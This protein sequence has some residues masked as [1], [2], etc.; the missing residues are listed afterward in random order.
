M[1]HNNLGGFGPDGGEPILRYGGVAS[2]D[3]VPI[4]LIIEVV[5]DPVGG[6][7]A[8]DTSVNGLGGA[9]PGTSSVDGDVTVTA[10]QLADGTWSVSVELSAEGCCGAPERDATAAQEAADK[11]NAM[12]PAQMDELFGLDVISTEPAVIVGTTRIVGGDVVAFSFIVDADSYDPDTSPASYAAALAEEMGPQ[13]SEG[14]GGFGQ[15]N[16]VFGSST[17]LRYTFVFGGTKGT[18]ADVIALTLFNWNLYDIGISGITDAAHAEHP[19]LMG[20]VMID[21]SDQGFTYTLPADAKLGTNIVV[22]ESGSETWFMSNNNAA[23]AASNG[24]STSSSTSNSPPTDPENLTN[25]QKANEVTLA[26]KQPTSSFELVFAFG[27]PKYGPTGISLAPW[28]GE[29]VGRMGHT[30]LFDGI[31]KSPPCPCPHGPAC[32]APCWGSGWRADGE[33]GV[34]SCPPL[35]PVCRHSSDPFPCAGPTCTVSMVF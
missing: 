33:P 8:G 7:G 19:D 2:L 15:I 10:K 26:F 3:G 28:T 6:H 17:R 1:L 20:M 5:G 34:H 14:G 32:I 4:D 16:L 9:L 21:S 35:K 31:T 13:F 30:V 11:L 12:T 22:H 27:E 29:P 23:A 25:Q 18:K 24:N